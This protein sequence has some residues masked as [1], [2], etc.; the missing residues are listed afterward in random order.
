M[1]DRDELHGIGGWLA[2]FLVTLGVFGPL[3]SIVSVIGLTNDPVAVSMMGDLWGTVV[4]F[5]WAVTG[6]ACAAMWFAVARF[7][8]VRNWNTVRIAIGVLWLVAA[9]GILVEPM[10]IALIAGLDPGTIY[11]GMGL[12]TIRPLI[13][14][15]VWTAYLL[16]SDRVANTY[17]YPENDGE[18]ALAQ[19]FD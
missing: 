3:A 14:A 12:A 1:A 18:D 17:R 7:F 16:K 4:T 11:G 19:V 9:L 10:G 13:Y 6:L 5:E 15:T 2:F 8:L